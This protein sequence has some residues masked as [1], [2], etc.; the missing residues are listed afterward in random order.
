[1]EKNK[2]ILE[3]QKHQI[4]LAK[5]HGLITEVIY[6]SVPRIPLPLGVG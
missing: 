6:D 5:E 3:I 4:K 1:M 2:H